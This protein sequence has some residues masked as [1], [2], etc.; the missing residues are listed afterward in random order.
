MA[1]LK[2]STLNVLSNIGNYREQI[3]ALLGGRHVEPKIERKI[4]EAFEAALDLRG[5]L[6][7]KDAFLETMEFRLKGIAL[8]LQRNVPAF[9]FQKGLLR[10]AHQIMPDP[11]AGSQM[12]RQAL[13]G[14]ESKAL[15]RCADELLDMGC[16]MTVE[17]MHSIMNTLR[18]FDTEYDEEYK[19]NADFSLKL[20]ENMSKSSWFN[21]MERGDNEWVKQKF[22]ITMLGILIN[23]KHSKKVVEHVVRNPEIY[24]NLCDGKDDIITSLALSATSHRFFQSL[25]EVNNESFERVMKSKLLHTNMHHIVFST[26]MELDFGKIPVTKNIPESF[27]VNTFRKG[28]SCLRM[29]ERE[30]KGMQKHWKALGYGN[31]KSLA[32]VG[33]RDPEVKERVKKHKEVIEVLNGICGDITLSRKYYPDVQ[34]YVRGN[35]Q[36]LEKLFIPQEDR[37]SE[38]VDRQK[39]LLLAILNMA[40]TNHL[41]YVEKNRALLQDPE[42]VKLL[43]DVLGRNSPRGAKQREEDFCEHVVGIMLKDDPK[44]KAF[45]HISKSVYDLLIAGRDDFGPDMARQV[46]WKS[47]EIK[48]QFLESDMEL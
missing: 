29:T 48:R 34:S 9:L 40:E 27:F 39:A 22:V 20:I 5:Y 6:G 16:V 21:T 32:E 11:T 8:E 2:P 41:I 3:G 19:I 17:D 12:L 43:V 30:Y 37:I 36:V 31:G 23:D 15:N 38:S 45:Q 26:Y 46:N 24:S 44:A 10:K 35:Y 33:S 28:I 18:R 14:L 1:E 25:S 13:M 47:S 42:V 4:D 7:P